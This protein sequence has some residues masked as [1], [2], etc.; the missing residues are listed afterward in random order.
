MAQE[1]IDSQDGLRV[2]VCGSQRFEDKSFVFGLLNGFDQ[3]FHISAVIS[4][5]F[6]GA[7][8]IA[9]EWAKEHGIP[10]ERI[11]I[12]D[13]ERMKLA[14]FDSGRDIP[15]L[16]LKSDPMYRKGFE[17]LRDSAASVVLAIPNP[18]GELGA[19]C[20]C[21]KRMASMINIECIDGSEAMRHVAAK[22]QEAVE[23]E[24]QANASTAPAGRL[25]K[26]SV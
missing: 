21:L 26:A 2:L 17:K 24:A 12:A 20:A 11:N 14:Y 9:K 23:L 19:T 15:P 1:Q 13:T 18:E 3:H 5:P 16:A 22:M 8:E 6:S 4:G 7:D 10:Y 25:A